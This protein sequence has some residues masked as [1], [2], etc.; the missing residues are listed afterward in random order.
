VVFLRDQPQFR[1]ATLYPGGIAFSRDSGHSWMSLDVTNADPNQ[2]PIELPQ[3]AFY[4]WRPNM[5]G[6]SSVY[7]AL[8]G[9]GVKRIDGR[10]ATLQQGTFKFCPSCVTSISMGEPHNVSVHV[11][12]LD[13][14]VPLR[15]A[16]DG[17]Y[18]G[19]ILFDVAKLRTLDY[20]FIVDGRV[21]PGGRREITDD[22]LRH[23]VALFTNPLLMPVMTPRG[24]PQTDLN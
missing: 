9:K 2:Q 19:S 1:F 13:M 4:D 8:Q 16:P 7:V 14:D 18:Q 22:E 11:N 3:S 5:L 20:Y 12:T 21:V 6:N 17:L 10:F 23:G 15:P 24:Q